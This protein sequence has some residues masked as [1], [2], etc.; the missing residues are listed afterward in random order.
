M[1]LG[2]CSRSP[3]LQCRGMRGTAFALSWKQGLPAH[4]AGEAALLPSANPP[5]APGR[6]DAGGWV[7]VLLCPPPRVDPL[8]PPCLGKE[9][10]HPRGAA[11]GWHGTPLPTLLPARAEGCRTTGCLHQKPQQ[12]GRNQEGSRSQAGV[13][14][15][16]GPPAPASHRRAQPAKQ[17]QP[18][19]DARRTSQ[20][21]F[22]APSPARRGPDG[23]DP[24][25]LRPH[26]CWGHGRQRTLRPAPTCTAAVG[27][28]ASR[29]K[30]A[31]P[32]CAPEACTPQ[33]R[34]SARLQC[35]LC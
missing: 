15:L 28:W 31:A 30:G 21:F 2:L 3:S 29:S 10:C 9:R 5:S 14:P 13:R 23:T 17:A 1:K 16:P 26:L 8:L 33:R 19:P 12:L 4:Q 7:T 22:P 18:S 32:R 25:L 20:A 34:S 35:S 27:P 11:D 6:A 24:A